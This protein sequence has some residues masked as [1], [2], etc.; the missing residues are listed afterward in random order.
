M[1]GRG[2]KL[3]IRR[4]YGHISPSGP[5]DLPK[6][7]PCHRGVC[8]SNATQLHPGETLDL[9]ILVDRP[10]I[11]VRQLRPHFG[12]ICGAFLSSKHHPT[13]AVYMFCLVLSPCLFGCGLVLA[14]RWYDQHTTYVF[15]GVR[16]RWPSRLGV[17]QLRLNLHHFSDAPLSTQTAPHT[18]HDV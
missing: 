16:A 18:P 2:S 3:L 12:T 13:R 15:S 4:C 7:Y 5:P 10:V 6:P 1:P 9:R 8:P 17:R 11:E 14:T